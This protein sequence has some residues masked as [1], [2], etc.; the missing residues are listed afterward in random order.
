MPQLLAR[1]DRML[2]ERAKLAR[3]VELLDALQEIAADSG[4]DLSF[5]SGEHQSVLRDAQAL[6]NRHAKWPTALEALHGVIYD[7]YV[8]AMKFAG[9]D[10]RG[11][12]VHGSL[13]RI[14]DNYDNDD[15]PSLLAFFAA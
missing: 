10:V 1:L 2:A 6:R 13:G 11:P 7:I 12:E 15:L 14:L 5:L 9:R 8:D 4:G 3:D